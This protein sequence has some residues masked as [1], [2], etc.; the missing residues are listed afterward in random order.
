MSDEVNKKEKLPKLYLRGLEHA[1]KVGAVSVMSLQKKFNVQH[2]VAYSMLC[3]MIEHGFVRDEG[4]KDSLKTTIMR[5]DEFYR[6]VEERGISLKTKREKQ[7]TVEE[8]LYKIC[9]RFA[10]RRGVITPQLLM[11]EL[12]L[13]R[14]RAAAVVDRMNEE[15]LLKREIPI[16]W[17]VL[18][19]KEQFKEIYGE[20]V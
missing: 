12:A 18:M 19:T 14:V 20:D 8:G 4:G 7:R 13:G 3:W 15:K 17:R 5:E 11:S 10:I 16:G 9:L 1:V 2:Q 6:M